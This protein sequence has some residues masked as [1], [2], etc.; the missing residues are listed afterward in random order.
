[1]K[2]FIFG[3]FLQSFE[4]LELLSFVNFSRSLLAFIFGL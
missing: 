4:P 1:M 3:N 2:D